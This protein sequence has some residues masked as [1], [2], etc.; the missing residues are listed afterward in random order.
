MNNWLGDFE[1]HTEINLAIFVVVLLIVTAFVMLTT[2]FQ[3]YKAATVNPADNL[4]YE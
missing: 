3:A 4:K 1:Y 2:G